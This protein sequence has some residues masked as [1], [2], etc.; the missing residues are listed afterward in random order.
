MNKVNLEDLHLM[1]I[2]VL[3]SKNMILGEDENNNSEIEFSDDDNLQT[4]GFDSFCF[5]QLV[6]MLEEKYNVEFTDENLVLSELNT[7]S[8]IKYTIENIL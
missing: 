2:Q 8:K 7:V 1:I 4:I 5:I 3:H 6:V